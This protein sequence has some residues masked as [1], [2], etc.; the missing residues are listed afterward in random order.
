MFVF[1]RIKLIISQGS[2][3]GRLI[4]DLADCTLRYERCRHRSI[5]F[6]SN[7]VLKTH[8]VENTVL[9]LDVSGSDLK[10]M[11]RVALSAQLLAALLLGHGRDSR[12]QLP[13]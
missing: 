3:L 12:Q 6:A 4:S 11:R 5:A 9:V 1:F 13:M 8:K 10:T 7:K 2:A